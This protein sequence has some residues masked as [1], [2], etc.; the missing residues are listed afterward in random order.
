MYLK[1]KKNSFSTECNFKQ[2]LLDR[3][4]PSYN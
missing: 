2:L 4:G 1:I 3:K